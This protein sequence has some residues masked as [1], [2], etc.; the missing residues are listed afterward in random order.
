MP[1]QFVLKI[2]DVSKFY[3][4]KPVLQDI[5]LSFYY[6]AKIGIVGENG[7]GKSTLLR[8]MAGLDTDIMGNSQLTKNMRV[9][10]VPQEPRLNPEKTVRGNLEE[11]VKPVHDL[12]S[13]YDE[14]CNKM[15]EKLSE[16]EMMKLGDEMDRLQT[17]I[18]KVDGWEI[19][20]ML[21]IPPTHSCF[22]LTIPT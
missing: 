14:V 12:I 2:T 4:D 16:E 20:R 7:S 13:R 1:P 21:D 19:D 3:D 9:C 15:G 22:R 10:H 5:S 18:D 17:E 6:G 11:A 8:I